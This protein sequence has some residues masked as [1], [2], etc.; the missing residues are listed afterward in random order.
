[1]TPEQKR[2][3]RYAWLTGLAILIIIALVDLTVHHHAHFEGT[4]FVVDSMPEFYP[5]FG[6]LAAFL[7]I[8]VAKTLAI[9]L[10]RKDTYYADD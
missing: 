6:F 5:M 2:H 4:E 1:M 9:A 3:A 10:K 7:L 8:L